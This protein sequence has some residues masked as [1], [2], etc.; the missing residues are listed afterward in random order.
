MT[1]LEN[2]QKSKE[3]RS[4]KASSQPKSTDEELELLRD[5]PSE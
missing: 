3:S 4:M 5:E 1:D 2:G